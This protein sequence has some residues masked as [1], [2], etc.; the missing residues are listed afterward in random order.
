MINR[1]KALFFVSCLF[2]VAGCK[3][4]PEKKEKEEQPAT[5]IPVSIYKNLEEQTLKTENEIWINKH[6]TKDFLL[7][8]VRR[9]D[10]PLF[11]KVSEEHTERNIWLLHPVYEAYKRMFE[12]ALADNVKLTITS[13]H[14]LFSEQIYEWELRWD[15]PRTNIVF[16]ND[17]EKA[18]YILQYRSMPGT[19]RHH[20]GTD[21]DLNSFKVSYFET[22][23]GKVVYNWLKE[24][25]AKY[26]FYQPYTPLDEKRPAGYQ[27]E[28][29][30]WSYK[31]LAQLML[32]KYLELV[33]I[34]DISGFKGDVATKELPIIS[35]WVCGISP[36]IK[37][38]D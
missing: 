2:V 10:N 18:R 1:Y 37:E 9:K 16:P 13:G 4:S 24:N 6:V 12:A 22:N 30:H 23:D 11:V 17:T 28:K 14:R 35:E 5:Y 34:D 15:N 25:A 8:K 36:Q 29:W 27:E 31:P 20:W 38:N 19:S 7:G 32:V 21:I 26:G 33:F 3:V